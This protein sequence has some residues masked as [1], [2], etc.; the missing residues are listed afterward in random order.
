[1]QSHGRRLV[2]MKLAD[3]L[4]LVQLNGGHKPLDVYGRNITLKVYTFDYIRRINT[5]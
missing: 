1:M 5:K 2:S 4:D 3:F